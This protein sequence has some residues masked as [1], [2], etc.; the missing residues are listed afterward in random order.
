MSWTNR[1]HHAEALENNSV[2]H[3]RL[4]P[5][6]SEYKSADGRINPEK[7]FRLIEDFISTLHVVSDIEPS[8]VAISYPGDVEFF[9]TF[10]VPVDGPDLIGMLDRL[11]Q[12][13]RRTPSQGGALVGVPFSF[14]LVLWGQKD[15]DAVSLGKLVEEA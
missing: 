4:K 1:R 8:R 10:R 12:E 14:Q 15:P 6:S 11:G 5:D 13:A 3:I 2:G 9:I 7:K